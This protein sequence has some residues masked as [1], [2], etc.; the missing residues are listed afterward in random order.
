MKNLHG[1]PCCFETFGLDEQNAQRILCDLVNKLNGCPTGFTGK[2]TWGSC[3]D[4]ANVKL[5]GTMTKPIIIDVCGKKLCFSE[6]P[7]VKDSSNATLTTP[8]SQTAACFSEF[9]ISRL[10]FFKNLEKNQDAIFEPSIGQ[11]G[12]SAEL[13]LLVQ[14][15]KQF[16]NGELTNIYT[17]RLICVDPINHIY[18][19][20]SQTFIVGSNEE[21]LIILGCRFK[22]EDCP[23]CC[24]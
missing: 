15:R 7:A 22:L 8:G 13:S 9:F 1:L 19:F 20:G 14:G 24:K 17:L 3:G 23:K 6:L 4:T 21:R 12:I 10:S 2:G 5:T 16:L 11:C 18:A